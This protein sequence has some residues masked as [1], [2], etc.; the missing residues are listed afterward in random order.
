M[1]YAS[2]TYL[3]RLNFLHMRDHGG[4]DKK[5]GGEWESKSGND[6]RVGNLCSSTSDLWGILYFPKINYR[7]RQGCHLCRP[8]LL[9]TYLPERDTPAFCSG[10]GAYSPTRVPCVHKEGPT[11]GWGLR[12]VRPHPQA[13][14]ILLT[15]IKSSPPV[16]N[17]GTFNWGLQN[18]G[19]KWFRKTG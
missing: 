2:P 13:S 14:D 10:T 19:G 1:V 15:T 3:S 6:P 8:E 4:K 16:P 12:G 7:L 5:S 17:W 11:G 9:G 18:Y